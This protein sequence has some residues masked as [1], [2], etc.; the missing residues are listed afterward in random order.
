MYNLEN[1]LKVI[2]HEDHSDPVVALAI[3]YHVGSGR[4][5]P[6][7][8]GFAHF[9]EHMLFQRSEHLPRNAFFKNISKMGGDFNGSTNTDG[10]NYFEMVPRDALEKILWMESD[11]MGYFIN[12]V[13]QGG[14]ERE[15]DIVSNEKR[16]NY[17]SQPYGHSSTIIAGDLFPQGHPYSWTTIGEIEDLR[18]ATLEDVKEFYTTYYTPGNATLVLTGDFDPQTAKDLINKYFGEIGKGNPVERPKI[19]PLTLE[20]D[21][22]IVWEDP[23][24]PM[25]Q[26]TVIY[27]GVEAYNKDAYALQYFASLFANSKKSPLYKVVVE[28]KKLAPEVRAFNIAREVAGYL[29][30]NIRTFPGVNLNDLQAAITEAFERFEKEGVDEQELQ[31]Q[32]VMQEVGLYNRMTGVLG[33]ALMLARDNEFGGRPDASLKDLEIYQSVSK[34]DIISVY[35]KY[36]KGK[37]CFNLSVVPKGKPELAL[38][39]STPAVI[40]EEKVAE[41]QMK[42]KE[43]KIVDEDYPLTR[44]SIDRSVE[45]SYLPNTPSVN[46]PPIWTFTLS[47]GMKVYG[48]TQDELPMIQAEIE[49][50]GGLLLDPADKPGLSFINARL[51]NEGTARR[52][53]EELESA[54]A[55]L[56]ARIYI[57]SSTEKMNIFVSCLSKNFSQVMELV[58]EIMLEPRFDEEALLKVKDQIIVM[59]RQN[60]VNPSEIANKAAEGLMFGKGST[61]SK[62]DFGTEES[63]NSITMDDIKSFYNKYISPSIANFNIAGAIDQAECEKALSSLEAEWGSKEVVIPAPVEGTPAESGRIYFVDYPGAP[64]SMIIVCKKGIP[65]NHPDY[66]PAMIVNQNLGSGSQGVLFDVLRLQRGYTYGAYSRFIGQSYFNTFVASSSVQ[67]SATKESLN[68]FRELIGNWSTSFNEEILANTKGSMLK[69][70]ASAFETLTDLVDMLCN[71]SGYGVP[72]D[73][74]KQQEETIKNFTL[75]QGK[76]IITRLMKPEEMYYVVVGDAKS[77]LKPLESLGMGKPVLIPN[78]LL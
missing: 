29:Q 13:T 23:K 35:E 76:D 77:Q 37:P 31:K 3:Q 46:V 22:R 67:G 59:L 9:F 52:T 63:V 72:F 20:G 75:G 74:V 39:G 18:S 51:M 5:K 14:L 56:G 34:E 25:P 54:I 6:G 73:Y 68:I 30:I 27:P 21:K 58:K 32:K 8:T 12:T 2:L 41:Q 1:G 33:K 65:F 66:F 10:T 26:L 60:A 24:A 15:I 7:K 40:K 57:S 38:A 28:E 42:S 50:K 78:P 69:A 4:E 70:K 61:F 43:G 36:I 71:I 44:S 45:P 55:L 16:Q 17:D 53:P 62:D 48:I 47:N 49:L 64:Q 11:R 19:L